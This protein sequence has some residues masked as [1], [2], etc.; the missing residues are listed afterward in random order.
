MNEETRGFVEHLTGRQD[1]L[2]VLLFGSWARGDHRPD[3]DVDL[4][5]IVRAGFHRGVE[6]FGRQAFEIIYVTESGAFDYWAAHRDDAAAMWEVA[7]IL[8]DKDGTMERLAG[9]A[10]ALLAEGKPPLDAAGIAHAR[11]D[12]DDQLRHIASIAG[13]DPATAN[14]LLANNVCRL[15]ELVFELGGRWTPPPKQRLA[16]IDVLDPELGAHLRRFYAAPGIAELALVRRIVG[17]VFGSRR[18]VDV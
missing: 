5:V 12:V 18:A 7:Q 2:G 13:A 11:F 14:L 1:V 16:R 8:H 10:R 3:S 15:T 9:R 17:L 4:V 6:Y